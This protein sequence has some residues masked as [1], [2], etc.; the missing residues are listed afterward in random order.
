MTTY[1]GA[2]QQSAL[3]IWDGRHANASRAQHSI[4]Q[5]AEANRDARRGEYPHTAVLARA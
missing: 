3:N 5:R 2:I 4:A 1:A